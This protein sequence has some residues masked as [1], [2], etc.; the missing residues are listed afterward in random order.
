[1]GRTNINSPL[2][3]SGI[4]LGYYPIDPGGWGVLVPGW[5]MRKDWDAPTDALA[6]GTRPE[7]WVQQTLPNHGWHRLTMVFTGDYV[8][9]SYLDKTY[10]E[11]VNDIRASNPPFMHVDYAADPPALTAG[12][13]GFYG[14]YTDMVQGEPSGAPLYVDD[15]EVYLPPYELP[16]EIT[17]ADPRWTLYE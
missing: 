15:I 12:G 11:I 1:M 16:G 8:V 9:D 13:I 3:A 10:E 6:G 7:E 4:R 2:W 17:T 14:A 5:G